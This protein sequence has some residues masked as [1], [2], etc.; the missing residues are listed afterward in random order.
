M[1]PADFSKD[2]FLTKLR[3]VIAQHC[4][5]K[6]VKATC[7]DEPHKRCNKETMK[8]ERHFHVALKLTGNFA[9]KRVAAAFHKA[10]G[11][12]ISFSFKLN[13]FVGNLQY[14]MLA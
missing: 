6:V 3:R 9:H 2:E 8:R 12:H 14:L 5:V 1:I 7:H 10:H 11:L 4:T 13:R